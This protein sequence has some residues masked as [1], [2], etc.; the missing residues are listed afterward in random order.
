MT[1]TLYILTKTQNKMQLIC[2]YSSTYLIRL[3]VYNN[4]ECPK[5]SLILCHWHGSIFNHK[6]L[7]NAYL[8]TVV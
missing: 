3:C 5:K 4:I 7:I 2:L 1:Q 8:M 6:E